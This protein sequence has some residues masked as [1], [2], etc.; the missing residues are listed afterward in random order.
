MTGPAAL[1]AD[2][3]I[4]GDRSMRMIEAVTFTVIIA[5]LLLVYRSIVTVLITPVMVV[6]SMLTAR[7]VVAFSGHTEIIGLVTNLLVRRQVTWQLRTMRSS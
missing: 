6:L 3:H 1:A 2:Q 4:A 5:M 7:G